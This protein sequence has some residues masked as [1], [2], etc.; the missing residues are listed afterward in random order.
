MLA[1]LYVRHMGDLYGGQMIKKKVPGSG[2]FYEFTNRE[3]LIT[4]IRAKLTDDLG[5]EANVAFQH[6]IN[7]MRELNEWCLEY[8]N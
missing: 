1:H 8:A 2:K 7:I 3:E 5:E 4:N 6:A